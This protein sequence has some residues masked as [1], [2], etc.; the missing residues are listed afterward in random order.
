MTGEQSGRA[1]WWGH[2]QVM[3]DTEKTRTRMN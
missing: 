1:E 3:E 2:Y